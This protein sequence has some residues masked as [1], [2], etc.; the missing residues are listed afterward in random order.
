[1]QEPPEREHSPW[2]TR[3]SV[4]RLLAPAG[5]PVGGTFLPLSTGRA[6]AA[7]SSLATIAGMLL[8]D[9]HRQIAE[10]VAKF[11]QTELNP[12]VDAWEAAEQFP[13]HEGFRQL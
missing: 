10:T 7:R 9:Q 1:A 12:N 8:T 6:A 11:V 3:P 2:L 13:A 4:D 5:T